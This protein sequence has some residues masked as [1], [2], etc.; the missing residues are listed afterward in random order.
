MSTTLRIGTAPIVINAGEWVQLDASADAIGQIT[1]SGERI[2]QTISPGGNYSYGGYTA[3][4]E[5]IISISG[6]S[7][8]VRVSSE[9]AAPVTDSQSRAMALPGQ[10]AAGRY[11]EIGSA[12]RVEVIDS[13]AST[14]TAH[15]LTL[16]TGV[17]YVDPDNGS[18]TSSGNSAAVPKKTL[19]T[20][21]WTGSRT[22]WA[23]GEMALMRSGSTYIHADTANPIDISGRYMGVYGGNSRA[24]VRGTNAGTIKAMVYSSEPTLPGGVFDIEFVGGDGSSTDRNGLQILNNTGAFVARNCL[25]RGHR[26]ANFGT[27]RAALSIERKLTSTKTAYTVAENVR[28]EDCIFH[29]NGGHGTLVYGVYGSTNSEGEWV[30]VDYINCHS[31]NNGLDQEAH[32]FSCTIV[33]K[34]KDVA[35]TYTPVSGTIYTV[36]T[37]SVFDS[38]TFVPTI[39]VVYLNLAG[40]MLWLRQN[41][42]TPTTPGVGEYGFDAAA[43]LLYL[44]ANRVLSADLLTAVPSTTKGVRYFHCLAEGNV[45]DGAEGH[46]FALDD[47]TSHNAI[48]QCTSGNN[49]GCGVSINR[50][51]FNRVLDC[52][53]YGNALPAVRLNQGLSNEIRRNIIRCSVDTGFASFKSAVLTDSGAG[54]LVTADLRN[55]WDKNQVFY[56]GSVATVIPMYALSSTNSKRVAMT[57]GRVVGFSTRVYNTANGNEMYLGVSTQGA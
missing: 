44:N 5:V 16:P 42:S 48:I 57:G 55:T 21:L 46:G 24:I 49:G 29:D 13:T 19:D 50:G 1:I 15:P 31:Y 36:P 47:W 41:T 30:G 33:T 23:Q 7:V 45:G 11:S 27:W 26:S 39:D 51:G 54:Y 37:T 43:Q 28:I 56:D 25:F 20:T 22:S 3:R 52:S 6:G 35:Q 14:I 32:G 2:F 40:Q 10:R 9:G 12:L 18:D 4:R 17:F 8:D 34:I 38:F 53:V